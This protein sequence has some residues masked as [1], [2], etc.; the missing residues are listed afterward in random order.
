[1]PVPIPRGDEMEKITPEQAK[2]IVVTPKVLEIAFGVKDRQIRYL[3]EEGVIKKTGRGKYLLIDNVKNYIAHL[4]ANKELKAPKEE[5]NK[6][7][8]DDE[9]AKHEL[10]KRQKTEIELKLMLKEVH[11]TEDIERVMADMLFKFRAKML[12]MPAK[13]APGLANEHD[14]IEVSKILKSTINEALIEL[15]DYSPDLFSE[16]VE[17]D[18]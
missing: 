11:K 15:A 10:A 3:A 7:S 12:A 16:G 2:A 13:L 17:D 5:E 4:K 14:V 18:S 9:K 6:I 1:M 8:F